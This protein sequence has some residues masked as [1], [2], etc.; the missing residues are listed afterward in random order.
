MTHLGQP[1][2][3]AT[4]AQQARNSAS[5]F[6]TALAQKDINGASHPLADVF[7]FS[8]DKAALEG[9]LTAKDAATFVNFMRHRFEDSA[10]SQSI[11]GSL[12]S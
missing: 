10:S 3:A 4:N 12:L 5:Q 6:A 1:L 8:D 11:S 7:N 9:E 2:E